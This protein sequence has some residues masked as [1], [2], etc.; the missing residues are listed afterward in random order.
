MAQTAVADGHDAPL[1]HV[2]FRPANRA[3]INQRNVL[4]DGIGVGITAGVGSF[5]SVFLVRLGASPFQVGLLTAMPALTGMLLSIPVGEFLSRRS[6]I[7]PWYARSRFLVLLCYVLTGLVPFFVS[8]SASPTVIILIWALATLPQTL[9]TVGFTV[10]MGGVAGPGGRFTLMSRRWTILGLTNSLTVVIVGQ[11]LNLFAFPLNYQVVFIGSA[12]GALIS[13]IFSSSLRLPP[14]EVREGQAGFISLI[15]D[16][17]GALRNNK[18]FLNFT[19]A[20]FVFRWGM[21][22]ALPLLPLYWVRSVGASDGQISAINSA[23]TFMMMLSY[24]LWTSVSR[25]RG[26]RFVLLI[27]AFGVSFY[28]LVTAFTTQPALLVVWAGIAGFFVGGVDLVFFDVVLDTCPRE[29]QAAYVGI[30]Q[31]TVQTATFLA[32]LAAAALAD[33]FGLVIALIVATVLRFAGAILLTVLG[34]GR[35]TPG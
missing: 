5:L 9:V 3:Q 26:E 4:I 19:A 22:L 24:F 6:N 33:A 34:V 28:P 17:G 25:R 11:L 29:N 21:A 16:H 30:Y 15:R 12:V 20:Q 32:P 13:V 23:S 10:V 35:E 8:Q 27:A 14:Q 7:V 18:P 2:L 1:R 31:T